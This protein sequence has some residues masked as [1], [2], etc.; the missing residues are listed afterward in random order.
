MY[1]L[2]AACEEKV[3]ADFEACSQHPKFG[4]L[5]AS[6]LTRTLKRDNLPVSQDR[7]GLLGLLLQLVDFQSL[8]VEKLLRLGRMT[9]SGP[10][11][12][13]LHREVDEAL[14]VR[15]GK[16]TQSPLNFQPKRRCLRHWTSDL[17]ASFG[18]RSASYTMSLLEVARS[19]HV[20]H[21]LQR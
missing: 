1:A 5:S 7:N 21:R 6:Q 12:E 4:E 8:S 20:C 14:R 11:A 13:E 3:A 2:K 15:Q 10:N 16:T 9:L 18:T 19:F 17:G